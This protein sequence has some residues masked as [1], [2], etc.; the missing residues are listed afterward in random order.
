MELLTTR[1]L[2]EIGRAAAW[3]A[4]Y[5]SRMSQCEFT[6]GDKE[7]FDA[8]L[9]I[10]QLGPVKLARAYKPRADVTADAFAAVWRTEHAAASQAAFAAAVTRHVANW[11]LPPENSNGLAL[12][13]PSVMKKLPTSKITRLVPSLKASRNMAAVC[14]VPPDVA[15]TS[16]AIRAEASPG[17]DSVETLK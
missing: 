11:P 9:R 7:R 15:E 2:P 12:V 14:G 3:G 5:A 16:S 8:E 1:G 6:P 13:E 4:I 10:G 17:V